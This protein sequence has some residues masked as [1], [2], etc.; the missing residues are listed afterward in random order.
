VHSKFAE[1]ALKSRLIQRGAA[2]AA[3]RVI[4]DCSLC[5]RT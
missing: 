1:N 5:M 3:P 4:Y 2:I